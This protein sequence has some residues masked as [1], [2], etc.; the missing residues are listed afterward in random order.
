MKKEY[1]VGDR[2]ELLNCGNGSYY[3]VGIREVVERNGVLSMLDTETKQITCSE[4]KF[5]QNIYRRLL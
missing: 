4:D 5:D 2:F 3:P 1:N